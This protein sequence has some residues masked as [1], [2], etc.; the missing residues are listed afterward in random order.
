LRS[1]VFVPGEPVSP[2]LADWHLAFA[3]LDPKLAAPLEIW[4]D[5]GPHE[6]IVELLPLPRRPGNCDWRLV[7]LHISALI[8]NVLCV[9][10]AKGV[11]IIAKESPLPADV[12]DGVA[13]N[14]FLPPDT[15]S[16]MPLSVIHTLGE[17]LFDAP[18]SLDTDRSRADALRETL[19][20][21]RPPRIGGTTTNASGLALA[22]NVGQHL[23]SWGLVR[24]DAGG[25]HSVTELHR[26][27][28]RPQGQALCFSKI[29]RQLMADIRQQLAGNADAIEAVGVA[30]AA[31]VVSGKILSSG[32]FGLFE[33]SCTET[34]NKM[35]ELLRRDCQSQFPGRT[36]AFANDA[37]AQALFAFHYAGGRELLA[38]AGNGSHMLSV[39]LGACPCVHCL[40]YAGESPVGLH[41]YGWLATR[42]STDRSS[43]SL[44][45]T[46]RFYLSHY[47]VAAVA[48]E[49]G[50]LDRYN[51]HPEAAIP[52]FHERLLSAEPGKRREAAKVY[53]IL[54]AHLAMLAYEIHRHRPLAAIIL[55]GSRANWIDQP[56]FAAIQD[57]FASFASGHGLPLGPVRIVL[58]EEASA[59]AG[60]VGVAHAALL[61][62]HAA[63]A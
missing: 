22:I 36:V 60:L 18:C 31:T 30:M 37:A 3:S 8:N 44:F 54:G 50:L 2:Y 45:A 6:P 59:Q 26:L 35:T 39:R 58:A 53:G 63:S 43:S 27:K 41:E 49:L 14:L 52:F 19:K 46:I 7:A 61:Q 40:D 4:F 16:N 62:A 23:T 9:Y 55:L 28:S 17:Q 25:R 10:G 57:G 48:H 33:G 38:G 29:F 42:L 11:S 15:F 13:K 12:L 5:R 24:I 21:P 34:L 20:K 47:G 1:T 56:A 51:L 32:P